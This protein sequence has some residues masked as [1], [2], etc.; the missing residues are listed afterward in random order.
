MFTHPG[1]AESGLFWWP[2][3][4]ACFGSLVWWPV[5]AA[6]FW[7]PVLAALLRYQRHP[8]RVLKNGAKTGQVLSRRQWLRG[9]LSWRPFLV[10]WLGGLFWR[11]VLVAY[12][13]LTKRSTRTQCIRVK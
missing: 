3:L 2:V 4:A 8:Q 9:G 6:F 1:E 10:A 12:F 13:G 11:P 5:L 7:W